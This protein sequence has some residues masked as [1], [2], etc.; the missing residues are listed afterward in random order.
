MKKLDRSKP[1]GTIHGDLEGR[2]FMQD[3]VIFDQSGVEFV[4]K[5]AALSAVGSN[6]PTEDEL[7]AEVERRV[8]ERVA[9]FDIGALVAA[10]VAKRLAEKPPAE[11]DE[12]GKPADPKAKGGK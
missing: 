6:V 5:P 11:P 7:N 1:F 2:T 10:E 8:A 4:G 3:G 9:A 12:P